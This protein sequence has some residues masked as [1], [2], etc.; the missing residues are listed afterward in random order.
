MTARNTD[1]HETEN[2]Y[3]DRK[4]H[5]M[6]FFE[7]AAKN[8][9]KAVFARYGQERGHHV[10]EKVKTGYSKSIRSSFPPVFKTR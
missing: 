3:V 7:R 6:A 2:Y 8:G 4:K 1:C 9:Q 5:S 10:L